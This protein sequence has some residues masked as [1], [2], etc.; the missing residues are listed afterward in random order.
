LL[1][2]INCSLRRSPLHRGGGERH[3]GRPRAARTLSLFAVTFY[4][5][6]RPIPCRRPNPSAQIP[7]VLGFFR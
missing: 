5:R 1:A 7:T 6:V 3:R 2:E 4:F